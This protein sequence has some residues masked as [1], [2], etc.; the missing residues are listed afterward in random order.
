MI[1]GPA[2]APAPSDPP[3]PVRSILVIDDEP[4]I[5]RA[6][7]NALADVADERQGSGSALRRP[8]F[9]GG[10]QELAAASLIRSRTFMFATDS[11][12]GIA[13]GR[14]CRTLSAND[15]IIS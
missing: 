12:S 11:L 4:Q 15:S 5:R 14:S 13:T 3:T 1:A 7:R 10:R 6:V 2:A 8:S 9:S